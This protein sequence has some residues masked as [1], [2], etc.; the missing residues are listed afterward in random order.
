[1]LAGG[2]PFISK[3]F[4]FSNQTCPYFRIFRAQLVSLC[5]RAMISLKTARLQ[6]N[7]FE[8]CFPLCFMGSGSPLAHRYHVPT[9]SMVENLEVSCF[10]G[11]VS[12]HWTKQPNSQPP[13][14]GHKGSKLK[15]TH[16]Q[17]TFCCCFWFGVGTAAKCAAYGIK[18]VVL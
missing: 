12:L 1:M 8:L 4:L 11:H 7:I 10:I 5:G 18:I 2:R 13:P 9:I 17:D 15:L 16:S 3:C 6:N 14:T